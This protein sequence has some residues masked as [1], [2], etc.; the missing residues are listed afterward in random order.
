MRGVAFLFHEGAFMTHV[1]LRAARADDARGMTRASR[2]PRW[3]ASLLAIATSPSYVE[4]VPPQAHY[5]VSVDLDGVGARIEPEIYGQFS[6]HAGAGIYDGIWVGEDSQIANIRGIR[7]DVVAALKKLKVPVVRWPG[8]CFADQYSWRDGV[9]GRASRPARR[10]MWGGIETNHFGT[11]EFMDFAAQIGAK[12]FISVNVGTGSPKEAR[13]WLDYLTDPDGT[14]AAAERQRNGQK[15]PW[16]I[17]YI[18][19]GNEM[20]ACGGNMRPDYYVDQARQFSAFIT[21]HKRYLIASGPLDDDP[22][23]TET[24]MQNA[25]WTFPH[26]DLRVPFFQAISLHHYTSPDG[27]MVAYKP[28][29]G[30]ATGFDERGWFTM[31]KAALRMD[32]L[33]AGHTTIMDKHD[34]ERRVALV[35]DE[36]GTWYQPDPNVPALYQ[37]NTLRDAFVAA[38]TLNIF[39]RH[40]D[41]VKMANIAQTINTLQSMVL[42]DRERMLVTPTYHV[43]E[44]YVP[45]QAAVPLSARASGPVYQIG[46]D[47]LPGID[48]SAARGEDGNVY[49]S[50]SNLSPNRAAMISTNLMGEARGKLLTAPAMSSHNSFEAPASVTPR[51]FTAGDKGRRLAFELPPNQ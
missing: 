38:L 1:I 48:V 47:E 19:I 17:K 34:P 32:E 40:T 39:H 3:I 36:W 30:T 13:E 10:N 21:G 14:A 23:F 37:Q 43:F 15:E 12:P 16:E 25:S 44:M 9:G 11:H 50:V 6:E 27:E 31:L 42:T 20:W 51:P 24:L 35:V 2:V 46:T 28:D 7:S 26:T 45:F 33:I 22:R 41:R 4:A 49:L 18:G 5:E 8:G 29:R